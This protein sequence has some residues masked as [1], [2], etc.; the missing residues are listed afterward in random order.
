M[1]KAITAWGQMNVKAIGYGDIEDFLHAQEVSDKT[2][3]N[4]KS[5]LHSFF[6]KVKRREKIPMPDFP[7]TSFE[8]GWRKIIDKETQEA[9]IDEDIELLKEIP[10]GLLKL[11]FFRHS[12]GIYGAI[13]GDAFGNKY[14]YKWWIKA[15]DNLN[16]NGVDLYSGTRHPTV[17][18]LKFYWSPELIKSAGTIHSS[19]KAFEAISR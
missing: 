14:F 12:K 2:K 11:T 15:C 7:E 1:E 5:C 8:L 18:Y 19:N 3:S 6:K 13:A 10:R 4:M 16:V 17:T 9:I